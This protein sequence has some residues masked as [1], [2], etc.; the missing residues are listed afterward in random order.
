VTIEQLAISVFAEAAVIAGI[1]KIGTDYVKKIFQHYNL[2]TV[3]LPFVAWLLAFG[4]AVVATI[5]LEQPLTASE[6]ARNGLVSLAAGAGAVGLN[7]GVKTLNG[8][9]RNDA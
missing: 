9:R 3:W 4:V 6:L 2:P 8:G 1:A 7:E 5:A